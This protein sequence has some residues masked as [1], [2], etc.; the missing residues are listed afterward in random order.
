MSTTHSHAT[1]NK[2]GGPGRDRRPYNGKRKGTGGASEHDLESE[3][4]APVVGAGK[5]FL[6]VSFN[7]PLLI[8]HA[9]Y[10]SFG[11]SVRF[12]SGLLH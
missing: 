10:R 9:T 2:G 1:V 4:R 5:K 7:L 3:Q 8:E 11:P 6:A 12:R